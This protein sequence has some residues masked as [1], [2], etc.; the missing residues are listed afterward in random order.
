VMPTAR[1]QRER[2]RVGY[3]AGGKRR[4]CALRVSRAAHPWGLRD[5]QPTL[6]TP[7]ASRSLVALTGAA[8]AGRF[9][10]SL[11]L[12]MADLRWPGRFYAASGREKADWRWAQGL[13][14]RPSLYFKYNGFV[15][16]V[17]LRVSSEK[18]RRG[19]TWYSD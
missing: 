9:R 3:A 12:T 1:S 14:C 6:P 16:E 17:Q 11:P 8:H 5:G 18:N 15:L 7:R 19:N 13:G 2:I 4:A 10:L